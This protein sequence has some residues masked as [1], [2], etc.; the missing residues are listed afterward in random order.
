LGSFV[1]FHPFRAVFL[2]KNLY[3]TNLIDIFQSGHLKTR[4]TGA[5][6]E[7]NNPD[8]PFS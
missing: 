8:P 5:R 6:R 2:D 3:Y 1:I 7:E 4:Y